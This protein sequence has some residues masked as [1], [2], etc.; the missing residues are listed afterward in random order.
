MSIK[1][2]S[3]SPSPS[4]VMRSVWDYNLESEF[5]LIRFV[6]DDHPYILM[7]TEFLGGVVRPNADYNYFRHQNTS[8]HHL[9]LNSNVDVLKLI[10]V[11]LTLTDANGNLPDL[12]K[13]NTDTNTNNRYI[14]EFNFKDFDLSRDHHASESIDLL[15]RQ[16]ID[17]QRNHGYEINSVKF[18]EL[19]MSSGLV[20]NELSSSPSSVSKETFINF[21]SDVLFLIS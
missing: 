4:I 2:S 13:M 21:T 1:G 5:R 9:L 7:D 10:Q 14:C 16:R 17:F 18:S 19:T 6:I 3:P 15:K 12:G 8:D 11:G 20:C